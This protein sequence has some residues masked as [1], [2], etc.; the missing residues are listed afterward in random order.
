[1]FPN[2]D[3]FLGSR[4]GPY[5]PQMGRYIVGLHRVFDGRLP[6]ARKEKG[7]GR[8]CTFLSE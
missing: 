4:P 2:I 6:G 1:V 8:I 3:T 5:E 7:T